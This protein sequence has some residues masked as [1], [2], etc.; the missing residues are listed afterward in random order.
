VRI[1]EGAPRRDYEEALRSMGAILDQRGMRDIL[2]TETTDGYLVQGLAVPGDGEGWTDPA[3]RLMKETFMLLD[4]DVARFMDEGLARRSAGS[5]DSYAH[6]YENALRVL[7][8]YFDEQKP[9]DIFLFEQD[10][11]F[12]TRLHMSTPAGPRHA[13]ALSRRRLA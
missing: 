7:G 11:A 5:S 2:I 4:E 13:I 12:V 6:F 3:V 1:Y 8:R 9:H 10:R